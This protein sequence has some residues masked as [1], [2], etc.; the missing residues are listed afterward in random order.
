MILEATRILADALASPE[1][2]VNRQI[3][4]VARDADDKAPPH[5]KTIGDITR[6]R[7]AAEIEEPPSV[8]AF[9]V[10]PAGPATLGGE[11][12]AGS[13]RDSET[14]SIDVIYLGRE[15]DSAEGFA[16]MMMTFRAALRT[17]RVLMDN[18]QAADRTRNGVCIIGAEDVT[19]G[20]AEMPIESTGGTGALTVT[21]SGRD[22]VV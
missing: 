15:V 9:L 20:L 6:D 5:V 7:W 13:L 16:H 10:A 12:L 22:T 18:E 19:W 1:Y 4:T 14:V 21:F 17:L 11:V 2:G 8:P 3:D